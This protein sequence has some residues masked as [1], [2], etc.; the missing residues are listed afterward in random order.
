M[1]LP[2]LPMFL[3]FGMGKRNGFSLPFHGNFW[4]FG[5]FGKVLGRGGAPFPEH[6][7][8]NGIALNIAHFPLNIRVL[9]GLAF[10]ATGRLFIGLL[11]GS[12]R[13]PCTGDF[14]KGLFGLMNRFPAES[15]R[16][17]GFETVVFGLLNRLP[18]EVERF[19][20]CRRNC[21]LG[22]MFWPK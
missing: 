18:A 9:H 17:C 1:F 7:V 21:P 2:F 16:R 6:C 12:K 11:W 3:P 20:G 14:A 13:E 10:I 15:E 19:I 5:V 22:T 4:A 8:L